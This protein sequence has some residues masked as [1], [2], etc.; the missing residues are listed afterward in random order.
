MTKGAPGLFLFES[1]DEARFSTK[2]SGDDE[3]KKSEWL[4]QENNDTEFISCLLGD[5]PGEENRSGVPLKCLSVLPFKSLG[6]EY[7]PGVSGQTPFARERDCEN[8]SGEVCITL[9]LWFKMSS[10][11]E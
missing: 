1:E 4:E 3:D 5:Q 6:E 8:N 7:K 2:R 11:K 10:V 9:K